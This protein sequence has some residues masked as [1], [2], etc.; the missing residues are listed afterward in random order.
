MYAITSLI[1]YQQNRNTTYSDLPDIFELLKLITKLVFWYPHVPKSILQ[2]A[3]LLM[4]S[5]NLLDIWVKIIL[6]ND[7]A[8]WLIKHIVL[9]S[10]H[11]L[12]SFGMSKKEAVSQSKVQNIKKKK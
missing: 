2:L 3:H 10:S 8:A 11:S 9:M 6:H 5:S 1:F 7:F 4:Y 12:L